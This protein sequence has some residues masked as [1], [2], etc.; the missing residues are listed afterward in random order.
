MNYAMQNL[1]KDE[2]III[3]AKF[4]KWALIGSV[5]RSILFIVLA[6][7][8]KNI[9]PWLA[10]TI[11][12]EG[13]DASYPKSLDTMFGVISGVLWVLAILTFFLKLISLTSGSLAVTNRRV[14]GKFG[15][16]AVN[17]T[18]I[19]INKVDS[20]NIN[21]GFFGRIFHYYNLSISTAGNAQVGTGLRT[22]GKVFPAISNA[23]E[24]QN[25]ITEALESYAEEA[26]KAQA[27]E[28][29]AAMEKSH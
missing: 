22:T 20:A 24:V 2:K 4:S 12:P 15:V 11:V 9:M 5:V 17:A 27:Q 23:I 6:I 3:Q 18:D 8:I 1:K 26:R 21:A 14:I 29:A 7:V 28:I 19:P 25:A 13:E 10:K 16:L